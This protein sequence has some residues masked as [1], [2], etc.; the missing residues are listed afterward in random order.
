MI[1]LHRSF[2][3]SVDFLDQVHLSN[4]FSSWRYIFMVLPS[5]NWVQQTSRRLQSASPSKI[6]CIYIVQNR[7]VKSRVLFLLISS[8][9][10]MRHILDPQC[11]YS[12]RA[13]TSMFYLSLLK[14]GKFG[15]PDCY[16]GKCIVSLLC[17]L[18]L[19]VD[20]DW[21]EMPSTVALRERSLT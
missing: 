6:V 10:N 5:L 3:K 4:E 9:N 12:T 17:P 20:S 7:H 21:N 15:I 18:L 14:E 16:G 19:K 8:T 2:K 1:F 13:V 11:V